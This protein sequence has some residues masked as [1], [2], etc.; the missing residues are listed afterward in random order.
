MRQV[1]PEGG[2]FFHSDNVVS[3]CPIPEEMQ[4]L[5]TQLTE[6]FNALSTGSK[7]TIFLKPS[8]DKIQYYIANH[9]AKSICW[10]RNEKPDAMHEVAE[11]RVTNTLAQE[12]WNHMENFPAP[13]FIDTEDI[14]TLMHVLASLAVGK[15]ST[16]TTSASANCCSVSQMRV[17]QTDPHLPSQPG[18]LHSSCKF[19]MHSMGIPTS[20]K[21]M[22]L[23]S[24]SHN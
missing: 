18:K 1:H 8:S 12:Y 23:V 3:N 22:L 20:F 13:K 17:P 6:E 15:V 11:N 19:W 2:M 16:H 24:K 14:K 9:T 5:G 10:L 21:L 4:V 7:I